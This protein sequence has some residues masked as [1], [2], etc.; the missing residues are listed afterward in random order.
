MAVYLLLD[1][2]FKK[3]WA[4]SNACISPDK[5]LVNSLHT[6]FLPWNLLQKQKV[7]FN[8]LQKTIKKFN[9]F[10]LSSLHVAKNFSVTLN[11]FLD[12]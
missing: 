3:I 10:H 5:L 2:D 4:N 1:D 9:A 12:L 11:I 7:F 8:A 6:F